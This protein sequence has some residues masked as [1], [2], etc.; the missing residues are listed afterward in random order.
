MILGTGIDIVEI[1]RIAAI[2]ARQTSF[3][4]RILTPQELSRAETLSE[5]RRIEYIAGRFAA[6][7]AASKA[8]G[9]GIGSK[10]S[11]QDIAIISDVTGKPTLQISTAALSRL[12]PETINLQFHVSISHSKAYA[13]AQV[14]MEQA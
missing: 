9:T 4:T 6:K 5:N 1:E 7:E 10:L 13:I 12:F 3:A 14:I 8:L 11:F 2:C